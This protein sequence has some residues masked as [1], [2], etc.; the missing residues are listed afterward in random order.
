MAKKSIIIVTHRLSVVHFV[1]KI[2]VLKNAKIIEHGTH[3]ELI[4][5]WEICIFIS[6][7]IK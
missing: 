2:I 1:D 5:K 6:N 3:L 7:S 4:K